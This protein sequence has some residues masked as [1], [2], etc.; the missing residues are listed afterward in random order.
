M[1]SIFLF[2]NLTSKQLDF[3]LITHFFESI[4]IFTM[5]LAK[6]KLPLLS[7]FLTFYRIR[8]FFSEFKETVQLFNKIMFL[9][10]LPQ[11]LNLGKKSDSLAENYSKSMSYFLRAFSETVFPAVFEPS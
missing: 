6:T 1:F 10:V 9:L 8:Y 2:L 5:G 3:P 4:F 11:K 7:S